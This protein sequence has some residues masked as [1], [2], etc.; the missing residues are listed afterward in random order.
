MRR[1]R[2]ADRARRERMH[3]QPEEFK[4]AGKHSTA[5]LGAPSAVA[6]SAEMRLGACLL[7]LK[8][9]QPCMAHASWALGGGEVNAGGFIGFDFLF[10]TIQVDIIV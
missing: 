10:R 3:R 8:D 1:F 9:I 6:A 7:E 2:A 5:A 4:K